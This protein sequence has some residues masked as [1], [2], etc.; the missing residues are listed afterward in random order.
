MTNFRW[1]L[2]S[3]YLTGRKKLIQGASLILHKLAALLVALSLLVGFVSGCGEQQEQLPAQEILARSAKRMISLSG[4]EF[5][6][7]RSGQPVFVNIEQKIAFRRAEGQFL[8]PDRVAAKVR[9]IAPGVVS[10]VQIVGI[11]DAQWETNF[12]SGKWQLSDPRY[13]FNPALM[14]DVDKG[15]P[16]I[17]AKDM[18]NITLVGREELVEMPGKSMYAITASIHGESAYTITNGMID[19]DTLQ[20]KIWVDPLQFDVYR[21]LITDPANSAEQEDTIWQIDFWNFNGKF[22]IEEPVADNQ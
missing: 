22:V 8:A 7:N 4:Y 12:L 1:I 21:M 2:Y 15:I 13:S 20:A 19:K 17:L 3:E 18:E 14:F 9:V 10:D 5:L 11:G 16:K 6:I